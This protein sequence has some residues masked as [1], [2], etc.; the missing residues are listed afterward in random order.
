MF[1]FTFFFWSCG[2]PQGIGFDSNSHT[3]QVEKL[4]KA[5]K[6]KLKKKLGKKKKKE[7]K[8]RERGACPVQTCRSDGDT[9][10][11]KKKDK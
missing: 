9:Q 11:T 7:K 8:T 6:I 10:I 3:W 2:W 1:F 4:G 5:L